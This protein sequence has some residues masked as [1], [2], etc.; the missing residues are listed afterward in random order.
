M[1]SSSQTAYSVRQRIY[2]TN[3][4]TYYDANIVAYHKHR[5]LLS[6]YAAKLY[7]K[8]IILILIMVLI[9]YAT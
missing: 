3:Y 9:L 2:A 8:Y 5:I 4:D 1:V 6:I 7:Y